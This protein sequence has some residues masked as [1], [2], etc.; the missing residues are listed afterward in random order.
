MLQIGLTGGIG[1]GKSTVAQIFSVL[2]IPVFKADDEA[3]KLMN[4][5]G[6]L[7]EKMIAL[8]G[9][10]SYTALGLNRK[11]IADIVFNNKY[12]L[13]QLNAIVHPAT[14]ANYNNWVLQQKSAYV[15]KEA[16]LMFEAGSADNLNFVIGVFAPKHLRYKRVMQ[17]D[18]ITREQV[19]ARMQHQIDESIKLRLCDAVVVNDEQQLLIQQVLTLHHQFLAL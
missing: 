19:E 3:K 17:R 1:S 6:E 12:K 4:D 11:F 18:N 14:I 5:S 16:A 15:I 10:E 2:G 8:F 7:K 13:E 9:A